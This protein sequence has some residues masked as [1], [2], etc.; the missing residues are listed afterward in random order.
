M[1]NILL[2]I[3]TGIARIL[4]NF[5]AGFAQF[6]FVDTKVNLVNF[7]K[8]IGSH[9]GYHYKFNHHKGIF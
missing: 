5:I 3:F 8:S 4:A 1:F 9:P 7:L 6:C 2:K